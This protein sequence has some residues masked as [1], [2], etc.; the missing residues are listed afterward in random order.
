[1]RY[2]KTVPGVG[3]VDTGEI[4]KGFELEKGQYVLFDP[5]EIAAVQLEAKRTL[6]LV[7]FVNQGEIDP[8]WFNC[9]YYIAS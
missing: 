4:V 6:D 1:M 5:E 8:I 3:P 2:Q 7:Q 9:P